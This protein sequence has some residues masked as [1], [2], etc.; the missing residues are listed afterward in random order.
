MHRPGARRCRSDR[1]AHLEPPLCAY[2]N[3][4]APGRAGCAPSEALQVGRSRQG[5]SELKWR[6]NTALVAACFVGEEKVFSTS[7]FAVK[8]RNCHSSLENCAG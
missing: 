1:A 2:R 6:A 5:N 4:R 3:R 8:K 7:K